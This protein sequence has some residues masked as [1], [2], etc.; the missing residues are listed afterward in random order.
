MQSKEEKIHWFHDLALL[1]KNNYFFC[2]PIRACLI[3]IG[4]GRG[5]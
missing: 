1:L 5:E 4:Q 2:L 3:D